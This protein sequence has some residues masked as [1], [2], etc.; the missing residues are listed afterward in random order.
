MWSVG[1]FLEIRNPVSL[2][3]AANREIDNVLI[4]ITLKSISTVTQLV[5]LQGFMIHCHGHY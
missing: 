1:F 5:S 2:K 3:F 4:S